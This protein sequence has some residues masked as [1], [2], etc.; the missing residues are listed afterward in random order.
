MDRKN[1]SLQHLRES[2]VGGPVNAV[3]GGSTLESIEGHVGAPR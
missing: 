2:S 3:N 1:I